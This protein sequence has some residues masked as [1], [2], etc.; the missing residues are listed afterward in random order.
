MIVLL[1]VS[2]LISACANLALWLDAR[3]AKARQRESADA[4]AMWRACAGDAVTALQDVQEQNVLLAHRLTTTRDLYIRRTQE[5]LAAGLKEV[6][7]WKN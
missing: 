7:L 5:C 3:N 2:L 4:C 6:G 1:A